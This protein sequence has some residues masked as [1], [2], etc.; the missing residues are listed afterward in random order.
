MG[1]KLSLTT[2]ATTNYLEPEKFTKNTT[3]AAQLFELF[4]VINS[5]ILLILIALIAVNELD[6]IKWFELGEFCPRL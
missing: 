5:S 4:I 3:N 1:G 6:S 2:I